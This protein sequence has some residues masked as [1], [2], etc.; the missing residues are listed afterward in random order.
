MRN[1][2]EMLE[3]AEAKRNQGAWVPGC[4][5]T[6]KPF[7]A[8]SGRMLLWCWQPSSGRHAHLDVETDM[9]LTDEEA[10]AHMAR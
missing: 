8:R 7:R 1:V 2:V 4:G 10:E 5:G 6:E 9:I 3:A